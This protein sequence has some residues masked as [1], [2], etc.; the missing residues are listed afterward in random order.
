[1]PNDRKAVAYGERGGPGTRKARPDLGD[2]RP[3]G[4][5]AGESGNGRA[6]CCIRDCGLDDRAIWSFGL[7]PSAPAKAQLFLNKLCKPTTGAI[8][9]EL[10]LE[11]VSPLGGQ[12][13]FSHRRT[14]NG[15]ARQPLH[16]RI[17]SCR[18]VSTRLLT[19]GRRVTPS[20]AKIAMAGQPVRG[21]EAGS[22]FR[23]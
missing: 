3:R 19:R 17:A 11:V 21:A 12:P 8:R 10:I 7:I 16:F 6:K 23:D 22:I 1:M 18:C 2:G 14:K 15:E 13:L 5:A 4:N 20:D 9:A